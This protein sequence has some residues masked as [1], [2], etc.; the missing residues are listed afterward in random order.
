[1]TLKIN[2][3][4]DVIYAI[5]KTKKFAEQKGMKNLNTMQL[6]TIISELAYN[7]IKYAKNG[8]ISIRTDRNG[9]TVVA[10]DKGNG[11]KDINKAISDE[12]SSSGSL[13]IGLPGII[14]V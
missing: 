10:K 1:M 8:F 11:I 13:G 12:Y 3:E 2:T 14:Y 4:Q 5:S 7:I 9:I 6:A